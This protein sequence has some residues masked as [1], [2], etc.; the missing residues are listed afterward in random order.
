VAVYA[1]IV[2]TRRL[3]LA[4]LAQLHPQADEEELDRL[5][6]ELEAQTWPSEPLTDKPDFEAERG[7]ADAE[8]SLFP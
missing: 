6:A 1:N 3:P 7:A 4:V 2:T 5:L 8:P